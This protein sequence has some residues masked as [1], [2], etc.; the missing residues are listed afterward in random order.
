M[1]WALAGYCALYYLF[2]G[3]AINLAYHRVLSHRSFVLHKSLERF[4]VTLGL[5]AGTPIQ[6]AGTHRQ[7]HRC[8]DAG[9]DPHSPRDGFWHAHNG[10]YIGQ[11]HPLPCLLYALAGPL[12]MLLDSWHRPRSNRQFDHLAAD[13]AADP[14]YRWVSRPLPYQLIV[15]AHVTGFFGAAALL[16]GSVGVIALWATL[17][18]LFNVG[19][20]IDSVCHL[21]GDRPFAQAARAGNSRL[22]GYLALGDG[23]H[24]NHHRFPWS[25]R[26]G[27]LPGQP[28]WTDG[29]IRVIERLGLGAGARRVSADEVRRALQEDRHAV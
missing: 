6:W 15:I 16:G 22:L 25:A 29:T 7:H 28:D 5:P 18:V 1:M 26:H 19:D 11:R 4:L 8:V 12:R 2:A 17:V 3:L 20:A 10:W 14:Y 24:A 13:V 27:V 21:T 23:W 9:G